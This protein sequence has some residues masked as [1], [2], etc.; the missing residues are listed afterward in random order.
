MLIGGWHV[1]VWSVLFIAFT[2]LVPPRR[3]AVLAPIGLI[4]ALLGAVKLAPAV[5][6]YGG[7]SNIFM[8]GYPSGASLFAALVTSPTREGPLD[9]WEYE[10]YVGYV[11]FLVLCFGAVP[12]WQPAKRFLNLLLLPTAALIV[13]S[14]GNVYELT[15]FRLPG[16]VSRRVT[17]RLVILAILWLTLAG[18]VR[19]DHW[20]RRA[21]A[22][23]A[24]SIPVLVGV[25]FLAVQLMLRAQAWRPHLGP[26]LDGLP[27]DVIKTVPVEPLY[28]W[29]F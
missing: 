13:L 5:V 12:F 17:S 3:I 27:V 19:L 15:L 18:A 21:R 7:G 1:F 4:T 10:A 22:S 29:A 25:W 9:P 8:G 6:T 2:C 26:P 11:G 23:F 16:F 20:W 28:Y 14:M 24:T